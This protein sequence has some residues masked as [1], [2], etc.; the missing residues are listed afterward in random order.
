M[1][2]SKRMF[3]FTVLS[4]VVLSTAT[5]WGQAEEE[6]DSAEPNPQQELFD[7]FSEKLSNSTLVGRFSIDGKE[8]E[9]KEDRYDLGSVTKMGDGDYWLFKTRI[10]Y[11]DYDV[12]VPLR[13]KVIWAQSTPVITLDSVKVPGLGTF[14]AR[15]LFD[16]NRYSG[17]WQHGEVGGHLFGRVERSAEDEQ[18]EAGAEQ[19]ATEPEGDASS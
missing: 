1:T 11:G 10:R 14:N 12:T 4:M 16:G 5:V 3:V 8:G 18:D 7:Q 19:E 6:G 15:V 13:L 2:S 9:L 17:T